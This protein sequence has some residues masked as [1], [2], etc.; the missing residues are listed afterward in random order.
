M[1]E[2][3]SDEWVQLL[4]VSVS[5][6]LIFQRELEEKPNFAS[7]ENIII[8]KRS[9]TTAFYVLTHRT[10]EVLVL[11]GTTFLFAWPANSLDG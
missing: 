11:H 6:I 5:P 8:L 4:L 2:H 3:S 1:R 7:L 10:R 9:G